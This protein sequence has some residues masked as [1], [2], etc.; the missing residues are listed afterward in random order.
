MGLDRVAEGLVG[1]GRDAVALHEGLGEGFRAFELRGGLG[2]AE[3]AQAVGAEF[4][5][6]A[7]GQ[8]GLG[9]DHGQRD[10][11][12][13]RPFAQRDDVR[14]GQVGQAG[15]ERG[16]AIAGRDKDLLDLRGLL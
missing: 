4:V 15:I 8:R 2:R 14:H 9:A 12:G 1:R 13:L 11:V 5:D 7:S 6:H 16:A 3:D 10:A